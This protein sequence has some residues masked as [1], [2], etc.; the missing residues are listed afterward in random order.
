MDE[1]LRAEP[2]DEEALLGLQAMEIGWRVGRHAFHPDLPLRLVGLR[3]A[4]R[5]RTFLARAA[6]GFTPRL[7]VQLGR[8]FAEG[9]LGGALQTAWVW[10]RMHEDT[11]L[12]TE[13]EICIREAR[14]LP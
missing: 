10:A 14:W 12:A 4:E 9:Y 5:T 7:R 6:C 3:V 8:A 1:G 11:T 13:V 2:P